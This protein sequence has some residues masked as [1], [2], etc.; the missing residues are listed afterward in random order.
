MPLQAE[1]IAHA[2]RTDAHSL[3]LLARFRATYL[4]CS[5]YITL[6]LSGSLA[7]CLPLK[8]QNLWVV[9]PRCTLLIRCRSTLVALWGLV[10]LDRRLQRMTEQQEHNSESSVTSKYY[11]VQSFSVRWKATANAIA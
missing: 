2:R 8:R 11:T 5:S 3:Q 9:W 10:I 1:R 4:T 7:A 6:K